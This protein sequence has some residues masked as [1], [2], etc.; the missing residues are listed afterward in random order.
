[1]IR[2]AVCI[3][4]SIRYWKET[5]PLFEYWNKLYDDAEFIFFISTWKGY[6]TITESGTIIDISKADEYDYGSH[7]FIEDVSYHTEPNLWDK[8][9]EIEK[10]GY[11]F[12]KSCRLKFYSIKQ[13][14]TL[15]Q[16]YEKKNKMKFD[17]IIQIRNDLF[18]PK[19]ILDRCVNICQL[20]PFYYNS[21]FVMTPGGSKIEVP[22]YH[23]TLS[24][25][26]FT[27]SNSRTMDIVKNHW[28]ELDL[29]EYVQCHSSPAEFYSRH[30]ISNYNIITQPLLLRTGRQTKNGRPKPEVLD[31]L[32]NRK[33][34]AWIYKQSVDYLSKKYWMYE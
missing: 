11:N 34:V 22:S 25:D 4:G 10:Q 16:K 30:D 27:F 24:N 17:G 13:V 31:E 21:K 12:H 8:Q 23:L 7:N 18:I 15:R 6:T 33:G 14:Q 19:S 32:I 3:S 9:K 29:Q 2:I 28:D 1:M 26:N 5:Y 20:K